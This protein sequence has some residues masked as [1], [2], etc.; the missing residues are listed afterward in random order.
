MDMAPPKKRSP[1]NWDLF[2]AQFEEGAYDEYQVTLKLRDVA[3]GIPADP[4]L[5][6]GWLNSLNTEW[7]EEERARIAKATAESLPEVTEEKEARSW[8][9]FKR[10]EN[11]HLYL[12]GRCLKA[13]LKEA[14][15]IVKDIVP[16]G[17]KQV[18]K[19][20]GKQ[21]GVSNLKSKVADRCFVVEN[22]VFFQDRD[23]NRVTEDA[24]HREERPIHVMTPQGPR[25]SIKR[26]DILYDVSLTFTV[27]RLAT[28]DVPEDTLLACIAYIQQLGVGSDRSQGRGTGRVSDVDRTKD[29]NRSVPAA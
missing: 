8:V 21:Y 27:R 20:K 3:G 13:A 19:Y 26:T 5:I 25:S 24:T 16:N 23:G 11:G 17:G 12:E 7:S 18:G 6:Q 22:K 29:A 14:G 2:R 4:D 15:N 1:V 9:T 28:E 10:D